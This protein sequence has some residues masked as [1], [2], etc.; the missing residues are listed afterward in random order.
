MTQFPTYTTTHLKL[1]AKRFFATTSVESESFQ[2][3]ETDSNKRFGISMKDEGL[4]SL[5]G[6]T[7]HH[8][9]QRR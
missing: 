4:F 5:L 1:Y 8:T 6:V 9:K 3:F 2:A 7:A